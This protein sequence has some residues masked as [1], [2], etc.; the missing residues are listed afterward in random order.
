MF[1]RVR[2]QT[3]NR[4]QPTRVSRDVRK[5]M[6]SLLAYRGNRI[7]HHKRTP[8]LRVA[9]VG[10]LLLIPGVL[11]ISFLN[12]STANAST[13]TEQE[14]SFEGKIVN[15]TGQNITDG[16]YNMEFRIYTG[17][18]NEPTSSTG[19]TPVWTEDYLNNNSQGVSF[20]SGTYEVNLG[21]ICS[22]TTS[23]CEN[24]SN[25]AVNWN[26]YPLYLSLQIGSSSNCSTNNPGSGA[27]T[28]DC[29]GDTVMNPYVLLTSTPYALNSNELGGLTANSFGQLS[30]SETWTGANTFQPT[31]NLTGLVVGQ[32]TAASPTADVFDVTGASTGDFIQVTSTATNAGAVTIQSLGSNA[33][34]LQSGGTIN[35]GTAS[36]GNISIGNTASTSSLALQQEGIT[37]TITGS[38]TAPTEIIKTTTNSTTAFQIQSQSGAAD[39]MD[40]DT[41]DGWVGIGINAP[42]SRLTVPWVSGD[43]TPT[44]NIGSSNSSNNETALQAN[45]YSSAAVLGTSNTSTGV[46][47]H[48][49][50]GAGVYGVSSSGNGIEAQSAT[51]I[52][53]YFQSSSSSNT[54]PTLD[55]QAITG[56]T[57]DIFQVD[58]SGTPI[59]FKV[60][61]TGLVTASN[62]INLTGG[63]LDVGTSGTATS[64]LYVSGSVPTAVAGSGTGLGGAPWGIKVVGNYAY[65]TVNSTNT[66]K[67]YDVST[68]VSPSSVGSVSTTGTGP[69]AL[70]VQGQYAYVVETSG[71]KLEVFNISNPAG[72]VS[73]GTATTGNTPNG[74]YVQG[75]YAYVVNAG[76]SNTLQVFDISNP[77]DPVSVGSISTGSVTGPQNVFVQGKYAYVTDASTVGFQ[78]FNVSNPTSPSLTSTYTTGLGKPYGLYV[79]GKYAYITNNLTGGSGTM[80]ILNIANPASVSSVKTVT[81]GDGPSDVYVQGRYAYTVSYNGDTLSTIDVSSP[82]SAAVVGTPLSLGSVNP[83][84]LAVVGRYAYVAENGSTQFQTFDLGGEYSQQ[85]QAGGIETG[86]LSVDSNAIVSGDENIQGGLTVGTAAEVNGNFAN[87][88]A[89]LFQDGTNSSTAFQ[90]QNASGKNVLGADTSDGWALLGSASSVNGAVEFYNSTNSN[91]VELLSSATSTNYTLALPTTGGS[92]SQC[93]QSTSGSTTTATVLTFGSCSGGSGYINSQTTAQSANLYVQAATSGTVAG[94]FEANATG[95]GDILDLRNGSGTLV[96]SVSSAGAVKLQNSTNSANALQ[97]QTSGGSPTTVLSVDTIPNDTTATLTVGNTTASNSQVGIQ[98]SS[99]SNYGVEGS[100]STGTGLYGSTTSGTGYGVQGNGGTTSVG[101]YGVTSSAANAAVYGNNSGA[102]GGVV[103]VSNSG[104][105]VFGG[106]TSSGSGVFQAQAYTNSS[107]TIAAVQGGDGTNPQTTGL[108]FDA[109]SYSYANL[110]QIGMTGATTIS[111]D[112]DSANLFQIQPHAGGQDTFDVDTTDGYIGIDKTTPGRQLDI[113]VNNSTVNALPIRVAQS[114]SGNAGIELD[115]TSQD[116]YLG[117]DTTGAFSIASSTSVSTGRS[118]T[119]GYNGIGNTVETGDGGSTTYMNGNQY[120]A[121]TNGN[122]TNIYVYTTAAAGTG[123]V[124]IYTD[125]GSNAPGTKL[126]SSSSSVTL[127]ANS[128]NTFPVSSTAV[129]AGTKYWIVFEMSSATTDFGYSNNRPSDTTDWY[130]ASSSRVTYPSWASTFPTSTHAQGLTSSFYATVNGTGSSDSL[131]NPLLDLSST[132]QA[133]FQNSTDSTTAFQVQNAAGSAMFTI[134]NTDNA[135]DLG[136]NTDLVMSGTTAYISNPQGQTDSE[137]FGAGANVTAADSLAIGEGS[138]SIDPSDTSVGQDSNTYGS[139]GTAVGAY[140]G[141]NNTYAT[142]YST[143]LGAGAGSYGSYAIAI[144]EAASANQNSVA[145]GASATAGSYNSIALGNQATTTAEYQMVVGGDYASGSYIQNVYI[146]SGVTDTTP[147]SAA[148]Q[149]TGSG[150]TGT[151]AASLTLAGGAGYAISTGSDGGNLTLQGGN[152]GGSGN[153]AGG[154]VLIQ[155]GAATNTGAGGTV[156]VQSQTNSTTA[157]QIMNSGGTESELSVDTI[158]NCVG[159]GGTCYGSANGLYVPWISGD[160]SSEGAIYGGSTNGSDASAGVIG[161]SGSGIALQAYSNS[162]YGIQANSYSGVSAYFQSGSASNANATVFIQGAN[163]QVANNLIQT[164][165]YGGANLFSVNS[166]VGTDVQSGNG[167]VT[168]AFQVQNSVGVA[169]LD[170]DTTSTD[171]NGATVNYLTYPGFEVS[172]SGVPLG[173]STVTGGTLTQNAT[174]KYTYNGLFSAKDVIG[175]ANEGILTS[176]FVSAPPDVK[177]MISFEAMAT[178]GSITPASF[179]LKVNA[180][181]SQSCTPVGATNLNAT[182]FTQVYC[183]LTTAPTGT[184]TGLQITTSAASG[185]L[186]FDGVQMQPSTTFNGTNTITVPTAYQIGGIQLRGVI[187]NPVAIENEADSMNALQVINAEGTDTV[188]DVDTLDQTV[189]LTGTNTSASLEVLTNNSATTNSLETITANALTTGSALSF[190]STETTALTTGALIKVTANSATT[191]T[192]GLVQ[193]AANALTTGIGLNITSTS[194]AFTSG[195]LAA[196]TDNSATTSA[197]TGLVQISATGL[198][199]GYAMKITTGALTSGA[200]LS[201]NSG[202]GIALQFAN[203]DV[204]DLASSTATDAVVFKMPTTAT[205]STGTA[206]GLVFKNAAGTQEAHICTSSSQSEFY[207]TAFNAGDTDVAEDYNDVTNDLTPG[208]L[209]AM[210]PSGST[211]DIVAATQANQNLMMGIIST[212]PGVE[213]T[214]TQDSQTTTTLPNPKPV[215]LSGRVPTL[216]STENGSIAVGDPLTISSTPGVAMKATSSGEIIG[217]ALQAYSGTG[218]GTIEVFVQNSYNMVNDTA[219]DNLTVN[220]TLY[221]EGGIESMGP[222]DFYGESTFYKLVTFVDQAVFNQNVTFNGQ[223]T[224]NNDTGGFAV[225]HKGQTQVQVTFTTPYASN[226]VVTVSDN[227]GQFTSYSYKNLTTTGFTIVIP[228]AATQDINFSWTALSITNATTFQQPLTTP[229]STTSGGDSATT[230]TTTSSP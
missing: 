97:I 73:V 88:G 202:I 17:C 22:F 170:V 138:Q 136:N 157:F 154:N 50:S 118:S 39:V 6:T 2:A 187:E 87:G 75:S 200:A 4:L 72:P 77:A 189:D 174:R 64:Q 3:F 184:I 196:F 40:V 86:T 159:I 222:A 37:N 36:T 56:Q 172:N 218:T 48:S 61:A 134:D 165:T 85:L 180:S 103:G 95:T 110:F 109:Q 142:S 12:P 35:V 31:T 161:Q 10:A 181:T 114:G 63:N 162:G 126:V 216:V 84:T 177:Y 16:S 148:I 68:P 230:G 108:L 150:A 83:S 23:S 104:L 212:A 1:G 55:T 208:E 26:S 143:S 171:G 27:F 25:T 24:N 93:L 156:T 160:S 15:N 71:N 229:D 135:V 145:L 30:T 53:G 58:S 106:S 121:T 211:D 219:S 98:G 125:S 9:L 47:G 140:D 89:A 201:I 28:A 199:T 117:A 209:V 178:S 8:L 147:V 225:I 11:A 215:A 223:T 173:W 131:G 152:A 96:G 65:V 67:V 46:A 123:Q 130:G 191:A 207:A 132:G 146:G 176:N 164:E 217:R 144:G 74:I 45:S 62:G 43:T 203:S 213:L 204:F 155:G 194:N 149:G 91:T 100:S 210:D 32:T 133:L 214:G 139:Y 79:Q 42:T 60:S 18:T 102:G 168:T 227:D 115:T 193:I 228:Q 34:S 137:A 14:M 94:V 49:T 158:N 192:G 226:P 124:G 190:T 59:Y 198:T 78:V 205:C 5:V 224:F 105:G 221:A 76:S 70:A 183:A 167:N 54:Q 112:A 57:A 195:A 20:T 129:T 81:V 33:L 116:Y 92:A 21:S 41:T 90:V 29:G 141:F 111:P 206:Q 44:V 153:N 19:C 80:Q 82:A 175:A 220:G 99:Y 51:N 188:F 119:L 120:T 128:W 169:I 69:S 166:S 38:G 197:T 122:I 182:G 13:G 52:S 107:A 66:F 185:T 113:G 186:Y 179:T 101:V 163:A 151:T 127:T 7:A